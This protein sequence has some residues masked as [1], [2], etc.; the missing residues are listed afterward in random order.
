MVWSGTNRLRWGDEPQDAID[1]ARDKKAPTNFNPFDFAI[2]EKVPSSRATRVAVAKILA[3]D[4]ALRS[5]VDRIYQREW[6]RPARDNEFSH[7]IGRTT[8]LAR[9]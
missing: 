5:N 4:E 9:R 1:N 2:R 8:D 3:T 6:G 7:L